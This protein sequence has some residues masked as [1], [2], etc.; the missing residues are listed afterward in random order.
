[1]IYSAL[2]YFILITIR[3]MEKLIKVKDKYNSLDLLLD[4]LKNESSYESSKMYDSWEIRTDSKG[5]ME[6][7]LLIKKSSMH[8]I[9]VFFTDKNTVKITQVIPSKVMNAIFGT[10]KNK[11]QNIF[12]LVTSKIKGVFVSASQRKAFKEMKTVFNRA[13]A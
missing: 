11:R 10:N 8:G 4:F 12:E 9:K 5:L 1:M 3:Q 2:G 13:S 7:C 6:Q